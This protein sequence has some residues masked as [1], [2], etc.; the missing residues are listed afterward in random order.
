MLQAGD[1]LCRCGRRVKICTAAMKKENDVHN[2][3][4]ANGEK[5]KVIAALMPIKGVWTPENGPVP[6]IQKRQHDAFTFFHALSS[7]R[8]ATLEM[9]SQNGQLST[10]GPKNIYNNSS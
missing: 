9:K 7:S 3:L 10:M 4:Q 6:R 8:E 2:S 1:M 5:V